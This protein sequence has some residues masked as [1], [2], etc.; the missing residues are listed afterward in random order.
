MTALYKLSAIMKELAMLCFKNPNKPPSSEAAHASL[1]FAQVAWNRSLKH[2]LSDYRK[3]LNVFLR[4]NPRLW[5]ELK[6]TKPEKLINE[7]KKF[8]KAKFPKDTRVILVC[9]IREGNVHVEWC[10]DEDFPEAS[11]NARN[12]LETEYGPGRVVSE[13]TTL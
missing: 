10:E 12:R 4:S 3:L 1:L 5:S 6:S 9:G 7:L 8:K 2:D 13:P 11:I